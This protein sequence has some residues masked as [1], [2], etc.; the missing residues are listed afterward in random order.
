V[1]RAQRAAG[2]SP[3]AACGWCRLRPDCSEG[4]AYWSQREEER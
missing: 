1:L 4:A 3:G 2:V